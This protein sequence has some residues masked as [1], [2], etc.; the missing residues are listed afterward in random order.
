MLFK[1]GFFGLDKIVFFFEDIFFFL[2]IGFWCFI[3]LLGFDI[4]DKGV[5]L[6]LFVL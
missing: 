2:F 1:F 3:F 4:I 5:F 6:L